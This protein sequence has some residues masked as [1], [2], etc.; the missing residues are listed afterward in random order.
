MNG[1]DTNP[2]GQDPILAR[3]D[4]I[5]TGLAQLRAATAVQAAMLAQAALELATVAAERDEW[6]RRAM[7]CENGQPGPL[8]PPPSSIWW[9]TSRPELAQL[10]GPPNLADALGSP[11]PIGDRGQLAQ[12]V[13]GWLARAGGRLHQ[14]TGP[15]TWTTAVAAAE[16]GDLIMVTGSIGQI[17]KYRP[18]EG[19]RSGLPGRPIIILGVPDAVIDPN[20]QSNS[21]PAL[22]IAD[23]DHVW[24]I[25][26]SVA[27]SQFG[28]RINSCHG[29]EDHPIRLAWSAATD[30]GHAGIAVAG[31]GKTVAPAGPT[32]DRW[33]SSSW[34]VIDD[35]T[36]TRPGRIDTRY[37]ECVYLGNGASDNP[38]FLSRADHVWI[39]GSRL[40]DCT[41]DWVD[42]KPGCHDVWVMAN[43]L[44][45][46]TFRYGAGIQALYTG[47]ARP[48]W[49]DFDPR[50]HVLFNRAYGQ[51]PIA[52]G[53]SD[54][55]VQASLA[56]TRVAYNMAWGF[57]QPGIGVRARSEGPRDDFQSAAGERLVVAHNLFALGAGVVNAGAPRAGAQPFP[58]AAIVD[59]GNLVIPPVAGPADSGDG[60]GSVFIPDPLPGP[61]ADDHLGLDL[62]N[63]GLNILATAA[64]GQ[65]GP[66]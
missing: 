15:G 50:I 51:R 43:E 34:V 24:A 4:E 23:V 27:R 58:A 53:G 5:M 54:Y 33:G 25:G 61:V 10:G 45:G 16:P 62:G 3:I 47:V 65:P 31:S 49:Y 44:A 52:G 14:V 60:P 48:S 39:R 32:K 36:V 13:S 35:C 55:F 19:G 22:D 1:I 41:S 26:I 17:L 42:I 18:V 63:A 6:A 66:I 29:T 12:A 20:Y 9:S 40:E 37:G 2:P 64:T 56:G 28:I 57:D 46:G 7:A 11:L 8:D 21:Q 30:L 59:H 38:A